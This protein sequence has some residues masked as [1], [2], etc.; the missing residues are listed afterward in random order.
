MP[1]RVN[2]VLHAP[3]PDPARMIFRTI[4]R[5][6]AWLELQCRGVLSG[7]EDLVDEW[8]LEPYRWMMGQM[9]RRMPA[10]RGSYPVWVWAQPRPDLRSNRLLP[11][12]ERGI[13]LTLSV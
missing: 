4:Q 1:R 3:E 13:R 10:Y 6:S 5:E 9:A 7:R 2:H 12:G 8:F 11:R